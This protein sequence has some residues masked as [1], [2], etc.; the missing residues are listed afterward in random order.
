MPTTDEGP[1]VAE[2]ARQ[3]QGV[4][5]RFESLSSQLEHTFVR[6]DI[7]DMYKAFIDQKLSE[8]VTKADKLASMDKINTIETDLKELADKQTVQSLTSRVEALEDDKKWL[9]RL[10]IGFIVLGVLGAVFAA[11]KV[12]G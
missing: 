11:S 10:V 8:I 7:Y 12:G 3:L 6:R 2:L 5:Q 1:G 4:L 9:T